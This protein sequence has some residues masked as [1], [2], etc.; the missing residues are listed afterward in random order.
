MNQIKFIKQTDSFCPVFRRCVWRVC[1]ECA[2]VGAKLW[3]QLWSESGE[4]GRWDGF[5]WGSVQSELLGY[6]YFVSTVFTV[7][8][9]EGSK[10]VSEVTQFCVC[11]ACAYGKS[12]TDSVLSG[13]AGFLCVPRQIFS[14]VSCSTKP[15][16]SCR[17]QRLITSFR[18]GKSSCVA[19]G[20]EV[21][22]FDYGSWAVVAELG[23]GASVA[24]LFH[25]QQ[26]Q[27]PPR[28][29]CF[30]APIMLRSLAARPLLCLLRLGGAGRSQLIV[31]S[32]ACHLHVCQVKRARAHLR[33]PRPE[34]RSSFGESAVSSVRRQ[35]EFQRRRMVLFISSSAAF[36]RSSLQWFVLFSLHVA[37]LLG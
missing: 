32:N 9:L 28:L 6:L 16:S 4:F 11:H 24:R 5:C 30:C 13:K 25:P 8:F 3:V 18:V 7:C 12:F 2:S 14:Q 34:R 21:S 31:S 36:L 35:K 29:N 22:V 33:S 10:P 23:G 17:V 26:W 19:R 15:R 1:V 37:Q 27:I 20:G